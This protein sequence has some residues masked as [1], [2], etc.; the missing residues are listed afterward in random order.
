MLDTFST[1]NTAL[2]RAIQSGSEEMLPLL[3]CKLVASYAGLEGARLPQNVAGLTGFP[4]SAVRKVLR[5]AGLVGVD[6]HDFLA[7]ESL[8]TVQYRMCRHLGQMI[9]SVFYD[10]VLTH[11]APSQREQVKGVFWED[12]QGFST[13]KGTSIYNENEANHVIEL[14][15]QE[16]KKLNSMAPGDV[17]V[18]SMYEAQRRYIS[19]LEPRIRAFNVDSFQGQEA[20]VV[21]LTLSGAY[22][23]EF[24]NDKHRINVACSR[25]KDRLYIVGDEGIVRMPEDR[26]LRYDRPLV[27]PHQP[28]ERLLFTL[29]CFYCCT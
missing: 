16:T 24:L 14:W 8:L 25:A 27:L 19:S 9:S 5:Y 26:E 28:D 3:I 22:A 2:V 23:T 20:R 12:I 11:A 4:S 17:V 18:I 6:D 15:R 21:I 7:S 13:R 10:G 1:T 29:A